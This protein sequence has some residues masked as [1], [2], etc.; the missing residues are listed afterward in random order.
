MSTHPLETI[1]NAVPKAEI[2]IEKGT[3]SL[4]VLVAS[5]AQMFDDF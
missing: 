2:A 4:L 1:H 3:K 5:S